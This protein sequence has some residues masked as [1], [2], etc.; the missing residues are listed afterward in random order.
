MI[1]GAYNTPPPHTRLRF[2]LT[3]NDVP[4]LHCP[5][6]PHSALCLEVGK[7]YPAVKEA[8]ERA[9]LNLRAAAKPTGDALGALDV[10]GVP[11]AV[12]RPFALGCGTKQP[13]IMILSLGTVQKLLQSLAPPPKFLSAVIGTL[14]IHAE[15]EDDSASQCHSLALSLSPAPLSDTLSDSRV[16]TPQT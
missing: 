9:I 13:K 1:S 6:C 15:V 3:L 8:A 10:S 5:H 4:A 16:S 11:D 14:R 12:L 7:K 2:E